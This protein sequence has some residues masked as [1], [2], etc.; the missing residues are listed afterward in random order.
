MTG[1]S[2]RK[3]DGGRIPG[4]AA[5][6]NGIEI[7]CIFRH[8]NAKIVSFTLHAQNDGTYITSVA[9]ANALHQS[10]GAAWTAHLGYAIVNTVQFN[11]VVLRD[12]TFPEL[13][14][15]TSSD[16]PILGT[17]VVTPLPDDVALVLTENGNARGRG[18]KGRIYVMGFAADQ[19]Q[20]GG[21]ANDNLVVA[22]NAFGT[23][24]MT[25]L[26]VG[27]LSPAIAKPHRQEYIGLT[28]ALHAERPAAL[29]PVGSY[30]CRDNHWDTQRRRGLR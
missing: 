8:V 9:A 13:P 12:M 21:V 24:L 19:D 23:Q 15:F 28:G 29:T 10:I 17:S 22:M 27:G 25:A 1:Q 7:R 16:P 6:P 5:I 14:E 18:S 26:G 11:S 2:T 3:V 30:T 4:P 20:G